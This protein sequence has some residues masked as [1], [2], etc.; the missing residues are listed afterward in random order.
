MLKNVRILSKICCFIC[1]PTK[2]L[3]EVLNNEIG[4]NFDISRL[5]DCTSWEKYEN[6]ISGAISVSSYGLLELPTIF[7]KVFIYKFFD[8]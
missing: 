7:E 5:K 8:K 6:V 2:L 1:D 4:S 3:S